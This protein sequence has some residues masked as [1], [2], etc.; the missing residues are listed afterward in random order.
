MSNNLFLTICTPTSIVFKDY[1]ESISFTDY[2]GVR[3]ILKDHAPTVGIIKECILVIKPI[4]D[5]KIRFVASRGSYLVSKNN[6]NITV[7]YCLED[8]ESNI[9]SIITNRN[10]SIEILA[11][12]NH[13]ILDDSMNE[14]TIIKNL[15]KT[16]KV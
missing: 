3:M 8:N 16:K 11:N 13:H 10:K 4:N 1:I 6:L 15:V 12:E 5:K 14:L 2:N 9:N 7:G